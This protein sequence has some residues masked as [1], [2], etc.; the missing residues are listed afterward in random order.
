MTTRKGITAKVRFEI[1]KR[2]KFICQYCGRS[3]PDVV[4]HID[5]I[6]PIKEGGGNQFEN[7]ITSCVDC[8]LGKGARKLSDDNVLKKRKAQL[9]ELQERREQIGMMLEW[10]KGLEGLDNLS[11]EAF[12]ELLKDILPGRELTDEGKRRFSR[13]IR[14]FGLSELMECARI[15]AGQYLKYD[16]GRPTDASV[17]KT[18]DYIARI[19]ANRK[20]VRENPYIGELQAIR[21]KMLARFNYFNFHVGLSLME[22]AYKAGWNTQEISEMCDDCRN[23]SEFRGLMDIL[24]E[25]KQ[26]AVE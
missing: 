2:D 22:Q 21:A 23:W 9:D 3:A 12:S 18:L 26:G 8:N 1:F 10:Q 20:R 13:E 17:I 7:L 11:I 16:N 19:A 6:Q 25:G 5:H 4:L 14:R 15:S 24:R